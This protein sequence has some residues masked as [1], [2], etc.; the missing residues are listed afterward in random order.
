[1][2][3]P[4]V[5]PI[6]KWPGGKRRVMKDIR[7][8]VPTTYTTYHEPFLGG[9][10]VLFDLAPGKAVVS[11]INPEL[12]NL[13]TQVRDNLDAVLSILMV[14]EAAHSREHYLTIR[15]AD[16]MADFAQVIPAARAARTLYLNRT[17]FNGLYRVNS[18]GHFNTPFGDY[19]NPRI[20]DRE[21][22]TALHR[23]LNDNDVQLHAEGYDVALDRVVGTDNFIYL[24]PPYLPLSPSSS[25]V[26]YAKDGFGLT[27]QQDL[28]DRAAALD[29]A[30]NYVLLSNSDTPLTREL[31]TDFI[32]EPIQV[33]RSIGASKE[34]RVAVG[35]VLILGKHLHKTLQ[36]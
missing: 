31:Y 20:I 15:A 23:Y 35:E 7:R 14:H 17:C 10:A 19:K 2:T 21:G 11:D 28:R 25:F 16:R 26:G 6:M 24:D 5:K 36:A 1:M 33:G 13:Y 22:L 9:G 32:I 8:F 4:A 30:G 18:K 29:A 27:Q 34:T 3:A 12:V